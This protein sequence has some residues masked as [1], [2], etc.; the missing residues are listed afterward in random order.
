MRNRVRKALILIK[1]IFQSVIYSKKFFLLGIPNH[2]NLG[3]HAIAIA[4]EKILNDNFPKYKIINIET[5]LVVKYKYLFKKIIKNNLILY[6]GGGFLGS[7]WPNEEEMFEF[8]LKNYNNNKIIVLPQTIYFTKD[9]FGKAI[10]KKAKETY[11]KSNLII[12]ARENY[13][14]EFVKKH[15]NHV[16]VYLVP[17]MVLY[18]DKITNYKNRNN[19]LF[20]LRKDK[21]KKFQDY[22]IIENY[23]NNHLGKIDYTDTVINKNLSIK[24]REKYVNNKILEFSKYK[25]VITDRLHGMIF[26]FLAKTPCLVLEN[27]SYKILGVYDWIKD[28]QYIKLVD[29]KDIIKNLNI[30]KNNNTNYDFDKRHYEIMTEIIKDVI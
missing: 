23:I 11:S 3:D 5:D 16:L 28:C 14:Y 4:E 9:D 20:C 19:I 30:I 15:I 2:G 22:S 18:L 10:L 26:S 8:I 25:L 29:I 27:K 6:T 12:L 21:E 17:D 13:T 7:L 24:E 1:I